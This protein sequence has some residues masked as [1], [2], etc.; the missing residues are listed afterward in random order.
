MLMATPPSRSLDR[1]K[2]HDHA[3]S[4]E[5]EYGKEP[6]PEKYDPDEDKSWDISLLRYLLYGGVA[7]GLVALVILV[8]RRTVLVK[9]N[10]S[11][12]T[13]LD[14]EIEATDIRELDTETLIQ[15][16]KAEG[17]YRLTVRL[18][19]LSQLKRLTER[20]LIDWQPHKTN[21]DYLAELSGKGIA[22]RFQR[23][24]LAYEYVWY[25]GFELDKSRFEE[26][27]GQFR[28]FLR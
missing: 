17:N 4:S 9:G 5:F 24:T 28:S 21:Y 18:L 22:D 20:G 25:G 8:L 16:A 7:I 6:L 12:G 10:P 23:L 2:L 11:L 15:K 3:E 1:E 14:L 26:L 19:Y 13:D 27:E